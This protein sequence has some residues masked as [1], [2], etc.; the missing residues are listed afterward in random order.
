MF[1]FYFFDIFLYSRFHRVFPRLAA[2]SMILY[3]FAWLPPHCYRCLLFR[4]SIIAVRAEHCKTISK[5]LHILSAL[6]FLFHIR[7][8]SIQVASMLSCIVYS[9]WISPY[10]LDSMSVCMNVMIHNER[11]F[12]QDISIVMWVIMNQPY[13]HLQYF[14]SEP[15][16]TGY[17]YITVNYCICI[18]SIDWKLAISSQGLENE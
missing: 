11:S 7:S 3:S 15:L 18:L 6:T 16:L 2:A 4:N 13:R 12:S 9:Y 5:A 1:T 10:S 8:A 14:F 17:A